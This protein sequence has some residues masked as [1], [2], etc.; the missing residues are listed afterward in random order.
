[1]R[2]SYLGRQN[3]WVPIEKCETEIPI[4]EGSTSPSIKRTQFP[5]TL[6]WS[7]NVQKFQGLSLEQSVID[8]DLHKQRSFG[9]GQI[10]TEL[11]GVKSF[12]SLLHIGI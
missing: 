11:S 2:P 4:K 9:P 5:L 6:A 12:E 3:S 8:F 7:S 1:M 10:Y